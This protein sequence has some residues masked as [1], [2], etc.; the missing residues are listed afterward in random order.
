MF[1]V[2]E[3]ARYVSTCP[4]LSSDFSHGSVV[5]TSSCQSQQRLSGNLESSRTDSAPSMLPVPQPAPTF[6]DTQRQL[7][8]HSVAGVGAPQ[9]TASAPDTSD[10]SASQHVTANTV[11]GQQ[12]RD[13]ASI[14]KPQSTASAPNTNDVLASHA[15]ANVSTLQ[16]TVPTSTNTRDLWPFAGVDVSGGQK[17]QVVTDVGHGEYDNY[18]AAAS[19]QPPQPTDTVASVTQ[20]SPVHVTEPTTPLLQTAPPLT[21]DTSSFR[22]STPDT[23][24]NAAASGLVSEAIDSVDLPA[25]SRFVYHEENAC[26]HMFGISPAAGKFDGDLAASVSEPSVGSSEQTGRVPY[27]SLSVFSHVNMLDSGSR[28][29]FAVTGPSSDEMPYVD[30]PVEMMDASVSGPPRASDAVIVTGE[31][32]MSVSASSDVCQRTLAVDDTTM[33]FSSAVAE[34]GSND[35]TTHSSLDDSTRFVSTEILAQFLTSLLCSDNIQ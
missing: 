2:K 28:H 23:L 35:G 3:S 11:T 18:P 9:S 31:S 5:Q 4:D 22:T 25:S 17:A 21:V 20:L 27:T 33:S 14:G 24:T 34:Y 7:V 8:S 13:V 10:L 12:Q 29:A 19:Q 15:V 30:E 6:S 16:S 26:D 32:S 1:C